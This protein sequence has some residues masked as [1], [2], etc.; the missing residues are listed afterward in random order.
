MNLALGG[1]HEGISPTD[2]AGAY[3][4]IAN[5]GVYITPTFYTKVTDVN[6]NIIF[7]PKQEENRVMSEQN[8]YIEKDIL[9]QPVISG[10]ATYCAIKGI[11]TAAKTGT[12]NDDFDRWLCGF[13]P[14]YTAT[15]WYGYPHN[16][17]VEYSGNP[18]GKIWAAVMKNIHADLENAEFEEPKG[19]IK[20][21]VCKTSGKL[22]TESCSAVYTELFTKDNVPKESCEGHSASRICNDSGLLAT[23][24]CPNVT[25][26]NI[27]LPEKERNPKW[28]TQNVTQSI[29]GGTC[30]LHT[31]PTSPEQ[32]AEQ[33]S[34]TTTQP[35]VHENPTSNPSAHT[36]SYTETITKA[37]T[38]GENGSKKLTCSCGDTKTETIPATGK[39]TPG[40]WI[41]DSQPTATTPGSRHQKCSVCGTTV[42]T[43]AIPPT[44]SSGSE[45]PTPDTNTA[46]PP[47]T[48]P[49]T[50]QNTTP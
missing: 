38:C 19:I 6:D 49:E 9:T 23:E 16:A 13:T 46:I 45:T 43:E 7:E 22:A 33:N 24:F 32:P 11:E 21:S 1:L 17:G 50:S 27:Y 39:H 36:H 12:T 40:D 25:E 26:R 5:D 37:A 3:S 4:A 30:T 10:T 18:A 35:E 41:I 15:C 14:Y 2:M 20:Q 31:A 8:A 47:S 34:P 29:P 48:E 44:G 28:S 42:K